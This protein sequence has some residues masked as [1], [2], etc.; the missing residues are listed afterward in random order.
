[1]DQH[2][3]ASTGSQSQDCLPP[4]PVIGSQVETA[5]GGTVTYTAATPCV[6]YNGRN[7]YFCLAPCKA[8]FV[9]DPAHSC[10][11]HAFPHGAK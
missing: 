1:M 4:V 6:L 7:L 11:A 8:D 9:R 5:C 2:P 3:G 10:L